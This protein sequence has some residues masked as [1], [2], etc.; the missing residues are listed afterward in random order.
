MQAYDIQPCWPG[1]VEILGW[2]RVHLDPV[3]AFLQAVLA[4]QKCS[5]AGVCSREAD[6]APV[7]AYPRNVLVSKGQR[8]ILHWLSGYAEPR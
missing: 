8:I 2:L 5:T 6:P 4:R 7:Q 1:H 3:L